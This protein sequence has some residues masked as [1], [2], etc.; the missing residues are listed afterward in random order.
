MIQTNLEH[1]I[2]AIIN[3]PRFIMC[4]IA[5]QLT[6]FYMSLFITVKGTSDGMTDFD[7]VGKAKHILLISNF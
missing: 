4:V 7:F 1:D 5:N 3:Y 2:I 6:G